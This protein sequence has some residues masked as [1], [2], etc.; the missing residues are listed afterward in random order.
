MRLV[1]AIV[2]MVQ[3]AF[4]Q[5]GGGIAAGNAAGRGFAGHGAVGRS[6][7]VR[8]RHRSNRFENRF[9]GSYGDYGFWGDYPDAVGDPYLGLSPQ[10]SPAP[11]IVVI[12]PP[13]PAPIRPVQTVIHEYAAPSSGNAGTG[14]D[15]NTFTIALKDGSQRSAAAAWVQGGELH[16]LDSQGKQQMLSP[17]VID[18]E[19]TVRLNQEK[20]LRLQLPP[21]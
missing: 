13:T 9:I 21:D 18:R 7:V 15:A 5:H 3:A 11:S 20:H 2:L 8:T 6:S 10:E 14:I 17:D 12:A 19:T 16:Y 4:A 1:T